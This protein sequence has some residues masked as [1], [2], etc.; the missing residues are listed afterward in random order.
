MQTIYKRRG[1]VF[2]L[3]AGGKE[4]KIIFFEGH[5]RFGEEIEVEKPEAVVQIV[6]PKVSLPKRFY[7]ADRLLE[8]YPNL[9]EYSRDIR[10]AFLV[11]NSRLN[12]KVS[13]FLKEI[14]GYD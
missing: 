8:H 12:A 5:V 10:E 4:Y 9:R 3:R 1:Y 13:K 7:S 11:L 14:R 2:F 6:Y